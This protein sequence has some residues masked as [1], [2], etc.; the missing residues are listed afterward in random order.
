MLTVIFD[1]DFLSSFLQIERCELVK[2]FYQ[3]EQAFVPAAVYRELAQT[4]LLTSLLAVSW[5]HVPQVEPL[6]DET[7]LQNNTFQTLGA[8]ERACIT[9]ARTQT[10][11]II[12]MSD[13]KARRFAQSLDITVVNIPAFLLACK[14]T[15]LVSTEAMKQTIQDLKVKDF[16]DFRKD[17]RDELLR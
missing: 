7:L 1:A 6:P 8:G 9:L 13:N 12:L 3:I 10:D 14:M 17:V 4:D 5:L 2:E 16:Y 11:A 15:G